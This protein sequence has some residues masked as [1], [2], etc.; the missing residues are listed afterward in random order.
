LQL[1]TGEYVLAVAN[2][3]ALAERRAGE[4]WE[5]MLR[6]DHELARALSHP[7]RLDVALAAVGG[8]LAATHQHG[9]TRRDAPWRDEPASPSQLTRLVREGVPADLPWTKGDVADVL[10]ATTARQL[11]APAPEPSA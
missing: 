11:I 1:A 9:L 4:R 8:Y 5:L 3:I 2:G 10:A 7:T 6:L